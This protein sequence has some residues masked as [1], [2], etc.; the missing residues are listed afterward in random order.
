[1]GLWKQRA[2][3]TCYALPISKQALAE[4]NSLQTVVQLIV[5]NKEENDTWTFQW[6]KQSYY[7]SKL[8]KAGFT[9]LQA[10]H[11]FFLGL[12]I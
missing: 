2:L 8:Y 10:S 11:N 3:K 7:S 6:G 9:Y 4:L 1:M 5:Y 12:E